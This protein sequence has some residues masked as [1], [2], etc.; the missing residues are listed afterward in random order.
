[1][2]LPDLLKNNNINQQDQPQEVDIPVLRGKQGPKGDKPTPDELVEI[3][4]PLIH[5]PT[6]E[7]LIS[8]IKPLIPDP[9]QGDQGEPGR[10]YVLTQKD[11]QD[12]ADTIDVPIVDK[13]I[14]KTEVIKHVAEKDTPVEIVSKLESLKGEERLSAEAVKGLDDFVKRKAGG[15]IAKNYRTGVQ[16]IFSTDL[17]IAI[18]KKRGGYD[19]SVIGTTSLFDIFSYGNVLYQKKST[20]NVAYNPFKNSMQTIPGATL[21]VEKQDTFGLVSLPSEFSYIPFT[22]SRGRTQQYQT[23][24]DDRNDWR[25]LFM[26]TSSGKLTYYVSENGSDSN[27]GLTPDLPLKSIK[28]ALAKS[29]M[30]TVSVGNGVYDASLIPNGTESGNYNLLCSDQ[31]HLG[32]WLSFSGFAW[33]ITYPNLGVFTGTHGDQVTDVFDRNSL[34]PEGVFERFR[35]AASLAECA[36][37]YKSYFITGTTVYINYYKLPGND[38]QDVLFSTGGRIVLNNATDHVVYAEGGI[39]YASILLQSAGVSGAAPWAYLRDINQAKSSGLWDMVIS[40][41]YSVGSYGITMQKAGTQDGFNYHVQGSGDAPLAFEVN[42]AVLF[43]IGQSGSD[44]ATTLHD[45]AICLTV[46]ANYSSNGD[47]VVH[48]IAGTTRCL[49]GS[50]FS[51][52]QGE[53]CVRISGAGAVCY[54]ENCVLQGSATYDLLVGDAGTMRTRGTMFRHGLLDTSLSVIEEWV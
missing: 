19:L 18:S 54:M 41:G 24:V 45:G 3:I 48:D 11:K 8:I 46:N 35:K 4:K 53:C 49:L 6:K 14:E 28:T 17:S 2:P 23:N 1:M 51:A 29:D 16:D 36:L 21:L 34:M 15:V 33:D 40:K 37:Q 25:S 26:N 9:I 31:A 27:S 32:S 13:I 44:Q 10:D 7:A 30:I 50:V 20:Y 12:I 22:I 43:E 42:C 39:Y 52:I 47:Q 38:F 5:K